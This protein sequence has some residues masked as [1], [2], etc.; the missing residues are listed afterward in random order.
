MN[1][2]CFPV[3]TLHGIKVV[4]QRTDHGKQ[5]TVNGVPNVKDFSTKN[6]LVVK[7][8]MSKPEA[9]IMMMSHIIT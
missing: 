8:S 6:I 4:I 5:L 7:K 2:G 1:F 3:K 9:L